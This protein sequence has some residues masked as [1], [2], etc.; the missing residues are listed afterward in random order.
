MKS[1]DTRSV[2]V[3]HGARQMESAGATLRRMLPELVV[4]KQ[5]DGET[6]HFH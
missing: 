2:S 3:D 1:I 4:S 6:A 5:V